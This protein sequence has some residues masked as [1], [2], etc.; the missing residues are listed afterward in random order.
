MGVLTRVLHPDTGDEILI[1]LGHADAM[2]GYSIGDKPLEIDGVYEGC[3][4]FCP[5]TREAEYW[6]VII[7]DF[8][9]RAVEPMST[10]T[11]ATLNRRDVGSDVAWSMVN[12]ERDEVTKR[13]FGEST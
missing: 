13:W 9:I 11:I 2:R 6:W 4:R 12:A 1:R 10:R 8:T 5:E 3:G 7:K